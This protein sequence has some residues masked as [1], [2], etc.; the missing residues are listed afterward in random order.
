MARGLIEI[1]GELPPDSTLTAEP[2]AGQPEVC[3]YVR[4]SSREEDRQRLSPETQ[5]RVIRDYAK[6]N[7][8]LPLQMVH[9]RGSAGS[10]RGRPELLR[11]LEMCRGGQVKHVIVQ[12]STRLFREVREALNTFFEMEETH[13]VR[14]HSATEIGPGIDTPEGRLIRNQRLIYGQYEREVIGERTRRVL[15]ATK[16]VPES[17][18]NISP[19]MAYR[20]EKGLLMNGAEPFGYRYLKRGGGTKPRRTVLVEC[21]INHPILLRIHELAAEG[22]SPQAIAMHFLYTGVRCRRGRRKGL[23]VRRRLV[24]NV[25][26]RGWV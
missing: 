12:D 4:V 24:W 19:A 2:G 1:V 11:I 6:L 5:A 25:L 16:T 13:G 17:D 23:V 15:R 3:G 26:H 21:P 22:T 14:F 18:K 7:G 20:F 8:L 10:L 9:E